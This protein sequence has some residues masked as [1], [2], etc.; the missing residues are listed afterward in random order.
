MGTY[1]SK[2]LHDISKHCSFIIS[3]S[4]FQKSSCPRPLGEVRTQ[5]FH[6]Y[7]LWPRGDYNLLLFASPFI[8]LI[9]LQ[10]V[11]W[12]SA[13]IWEHIQAPFPRSPSE[14]MSSLCFQ[15]IMGGVS[16]EPRTVSSENSE[17]RAPRDR[18]GDFFTSINKH[19]VLQ[20]EFQYDLDTAHSN[21]SRGAFKSHKNST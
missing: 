16:R 1:L 8:D 5:A 13:N 2:S 15:S 18:M 6:N 10:I 17:I 4:L 21:S 20:L 19:N 11:P 9:S 12:K 14:S 3:D 7:T